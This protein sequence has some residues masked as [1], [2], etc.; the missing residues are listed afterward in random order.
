VGVA[1]LPL[2]LVYQVGKIFSNDHRYRWLRIGEPGSPAEIG[3]LVHRPVRVRPP[4]IR[5]G[6]LVGHP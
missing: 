5:D 2:D 3:A 4:D 6:R 1:D